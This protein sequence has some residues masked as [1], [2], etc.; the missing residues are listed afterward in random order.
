MVDFVI[1]AGDRLPSMSA[2]LS[3][4]NGVLNLTGCTVTF[5]YAPADKNSITAPRDKLAVIVDAPN[6]KVRVDWA[7]GDT[8]PA[9]YYEGEFLLTA[10]GGQYT[11]PNRGYLELLF[12]TPLP[13]PT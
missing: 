11:F 2:T 4:A 8:N 10:V 3:D 13:A 6:G 12:D 7:D 9:G 1:K 5:R